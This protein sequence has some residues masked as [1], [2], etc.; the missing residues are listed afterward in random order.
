MTVTL[1]RLTGAAG[2]AGPVS[3]TVSP[4]VTARW[5]G[6][7]FLGCVL[8]QRFSAPGMVPLLLPLVLLWV[9]AAVRF[10][11]AEIDRNRCA[12]W[13]AAF[14]VTGLIILV[15]MAFVPLPIIS[16]TSW[17][18]VMATWLPFI[19]RLVDRRIE[20]YKLALGH[21]VKVGV[22][23]AGACIVMMGIQ[24]AGVPYADVL[25]E[26]L[27][28]GLLLRGYATTYPIVYG[29]TIYKSN[30]W[31]GLE[32]A[33]VSIQLG[34]A[35]VVAILLHRRTRTVLFIAVGLFCTVAG[36]GM[37]IALVG[38]LALLFRRRRGVLAKS[39]LAM[40]VGVVAMLPTSFGQSFL[41]RATELN[42]P[43]TS[44]SLRVIDPYVELWPRWI[45]DPL[46]PLLGM[47][48]GS[49]QRVVN[50]SGM[51]GL[52][53]PNP[54]KIFFDYGLIAG[55]VLA[56]YLIY[57]HLDSPSPSLSLTFFF[58]LWT[59]QASTSSI[60]LASNVLIFAT[61]W[62]PR[63]GAPLDDIPVDPVRDRPPGRG[64]AP[65]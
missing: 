22:A 5:V 62:A 56:A 7:L 14:T 10:R 51:S 41:E 40:G 31:I 6:G 27:P 33:V 57:C 4:V 38:L 3:A 11:V 28:S 15:Q 32:P 9:V 12:L 37:L 8:L 65:P 64:G 47:G 13:L 54:A 59:L 52:L 49:S 21:V 58:S 55:V 45:L 35:L 20:T 17:L 26:S 16:D 63:L 30:A 39:G 44:T 25:R 24:L 18:L 42:R 29:S 36:S 60:V 61:L 46:T 19:V 34:A 53:V 50:G 2:V 1:A 43:T 48:P 23:L